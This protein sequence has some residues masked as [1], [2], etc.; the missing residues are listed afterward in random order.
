MQI[1]MQISSRHYLKFY[2]S[3]I[4]LIS[5]TIFEIKGVYTHVFMVK[6]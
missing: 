6:D 3:H 5:C 1:D 4:S 2:F